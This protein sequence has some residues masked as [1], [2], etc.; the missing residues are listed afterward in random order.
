MAFLDRSLIGEEGASEPHTEL[1]VDS[2]SPL[3][4]YNRPSDPLSSLAYELVALHILAPS[5]VSRQ[6]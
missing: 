1:S 2:V 6:Q 4:V 5:S 3:P